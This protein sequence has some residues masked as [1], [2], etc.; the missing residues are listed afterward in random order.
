M[1][2]D[3]E[4]DQGEVRTVRMVDPV[5]EDDLSRKTLTMMAGARGRNR[6]MD[7]ERND[8]GRGKGRRGMDRRGGRGRY[9]DN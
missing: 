6:A 8:R 7:R 4:D 2:V 3:E 1:E 9:M 5:N